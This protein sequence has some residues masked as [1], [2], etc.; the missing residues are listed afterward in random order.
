M[1]MAVTGILIGVPVIGF[2][3]FP[4][5]ADAT[6]SSKIAEVFLYMNGVWT[7]LRETCD[8][9]DPFG[10]VTHRALDLPDLYK[11]GPLVQY[12]TVRA[13]NAERVVVSATLEDI[14]LDILFWRQLR[15]PKG[16]KIVWEGKC[17]GKVFKWS[18]RETTVPARYLPSAYR[19]STS[20]N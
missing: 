3:L 20:A 8:R 13:E 2:L 1:V 9:G 19:T 12:V 5:R 6:A 14:Y 17:T 15:V 4:P 10:G 18:I 11:P 16:A 7:A